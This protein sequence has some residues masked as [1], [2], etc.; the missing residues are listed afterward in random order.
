MSKFDTLCP[1][2]KTFM[3]IFPICTFAFF[4]V[5]SFLFSA[6][7]TAQTGTLNVVA[8]STDHSELIKVETAGD[9]YTIY[10]AEGT[11]FKVVFRDSKIEFITKDDAGLDQI[12]FLDYPK[13]AKGLSITSQKVIS[14]TIENISNPAM[15]EVLGASSLDVKFVEGLEFKKDGL[16]LFS[17]SI[18]EGAVNIDPV[19]SSIDASSFSWYPMTSF[20][21][22]TN[23][24]SVMASN[25]TQLEI[26][27][28]E[29]KSNSKQNSLKIQF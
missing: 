29:N 11:D 10:S 5:F 1:S 19:D 12:V 6:S 22:V 27:N 23:Q 17:V 13:E 4:F 25:N 28:V 14:E 7:V 3:G 26:Q 8:E 18:S 20:F 21:N 24:A 15:A 2:R 16:H 9:N